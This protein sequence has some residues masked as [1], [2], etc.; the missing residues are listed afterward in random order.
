MYRT[1]D[2]EEIFIIDGHTHLW[3]GSKE[4]QKNIHG[5]TVHRL[6]LR[7]PLGAQPQGVCLAEGEVRQV[8]R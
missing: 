1:A 2:G 7:L 8:W 3:D 6:L 5:E 4:N